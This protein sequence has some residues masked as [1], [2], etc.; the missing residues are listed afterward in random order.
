M[1]TIKTKDWLCVLLGDLHVLSH[2]GLVIPNHPIQSADNRK[3]SAS[4]RQEWL[5]SCWMDFLAYVKAKAK[6]H[7]IALM[8]GGD[9]IDGPAH[10]RTLHTFGNRRDAVD[11]AV[12]LLKP[13]AN[14][15]S[16]HFG[17]TGTD[18]H[19]GEGGEDDVSIAKELGLDVREVWELEIG[20]RKL[21]WAHEAVR[22]G[23]RRNTIDSGMIALAK[24]IDDECQ[25]DPQRFRPD[26]IIG[27]H[28]H[29]S[30]RPVTVRGITVA[31]VGCWQLSTPWALQRF[32][33]KSVDV[34]ALLWKPRTMEVERKIYSQVKPPL[35][36]VNPPL[37]PYRAKR[38]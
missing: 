17:L 26:I 28:V 19:V 31:T 36:V 18:A 34:G 30:P 6:D 35:V 33:F 37:S 4:P 1:P 9:G 3:Y 7:H 16:A 32:P 12:E 25:F 15:A 20:G 14:I 8:F 23:Q 13:F 5:Y 38:A 24:D 2:T 29:R 22:V 11:M 21:L 10:H 27:H